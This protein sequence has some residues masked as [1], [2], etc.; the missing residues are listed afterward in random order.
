MHSTVAINAK[1]D[2]TRP[3][4]PPRRVE[5]DASALAGAEWLEGLAPSPAD[6]ALVDPAAAEVAELLLHTVPQRGKRVFDLL[7]ALPLLVV[8]LPVLALC[9]MAIK[10]TDGGPV[11]FRQERVGYRG[12]RF[13]ILKLRSMMVGSESLAAQLVGHNVTDGLLFRVAA[14]PRVT[15]IGKLIRRTAIDELPQLW[16]IVRGE[17]SLVG[18]RP[19]AVPPESFSLREQARH[20]VPPGLTGLW[21]VSGGN[22]LCYHEMI[23]HDLAYARGWSLWLDVKLMV[24]TVPA[25]LTRVGPS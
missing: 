11:L 5:A 10:L 8:S 2:V 20:A 14:D 7:V 19:L 6:H 16:N 1:L 18:P 24:R 17:M 4:A 13:R 23:D 25:L 15:W 12:R 3:P 22:E 21:Q 9:A